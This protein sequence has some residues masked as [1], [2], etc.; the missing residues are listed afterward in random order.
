MEALK[1]IQE[2]YHTSVFTDVDWNVPSFNLLK[3]CSFCTTLA[4]WKLSEQNIS[5]WALS[6]SYWLDLPEWM[7]LLKWFCNSANSPVH[8]Q[9]FF[10]CMQKMLSCLMER[11]NPL[12]GVTSK[13]SLHHGQTLLPALTCWLHEWQKLV[14]QQTAWYGSRR[15]RRH[16]GHSV[17]KAFGTG[18]TSS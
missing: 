6:P 17:W 11:F 9:P 14:P 5:H 18:S 3:G 7:P 13:S 8:L 1:K 12:F 4:H 15:S 16:N 2:I 10:L